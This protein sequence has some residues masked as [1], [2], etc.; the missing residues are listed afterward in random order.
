MGKISKRE[1]QLII[2]KNSVRNY[3]GTPQ[4][5]NTQILWKGTKF[6]VRTEGN[7]NRPPLYGQHPSSWT[8]KWEALRCMALQKTQLCDK[9]VNCVAFWIVLPWEL[10]GFLCLVTRKKRGRKKEK[11]RKSAEANMASEI[12]FILYNV[13][14]RAIPCSKGDGI[15]LRRETFTDP[16]QAV[17]M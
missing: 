5:T 14:V 7:A 10:C 16:E 2:S 6:I 4:E 9:C 12:L 3:K 17:C 13:Q 15:S 11:D 8:W 1:T